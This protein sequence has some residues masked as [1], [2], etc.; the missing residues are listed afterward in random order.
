M[1]I[2]PATRRQNVAYHEGEGRSWRDKLAATSETGNAGLK[3]GAYIRGNFTMS[4]WD[5]VPGLKTGHYMAIAEERVA[6]SSGSGL[7][8]DS[9]SQRM[10][11]THQREPSLK[12]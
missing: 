12:S 5:A 7:P 1:R 3:S 6:M 11:R 10:L 9:S 2:V 4:W 8:G